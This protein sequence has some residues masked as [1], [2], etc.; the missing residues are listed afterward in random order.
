MGRAWRQTAGGPRIGPD[1]HILRTIRRS[2]WSRTAGIDGSGGSGVVSPDRVPAEVFAPGEF[3]SEEIE[4]RGWTQNDLAI[5]M[6][7]RLRLV[8]GIIVGK[9]RITLDMARRLAKAFGTDVLYWLSLDSAYRR[10]H[11]FGK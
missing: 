1:V 3:I 2:S 11:G 5:R 10:H 9:K 8:K 7:C 6:G 4:A